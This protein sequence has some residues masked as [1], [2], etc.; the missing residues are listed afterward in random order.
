M[1]TYWASLKDKDQLTAHFYYDKNNQID[2][3]GINV[4]GKGNFIIDV[5]FTKSTSAGDAS[6]AKERCQSSIGN[7]ESLRSFAFLPEY[8]PGALQNQGGGL[9]DLGLLQF[10]YHKYVSPGQSRV[11]YLGTWDRETLQRQY[12]IIETLYTK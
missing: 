9:Y 10:R 11:C 5:Y 6:V 7:L 2:S 1:F 8:C 12:Y 4:K 3:N